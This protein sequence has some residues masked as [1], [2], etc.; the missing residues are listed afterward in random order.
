MTLGDDKPCIYI[1][2]ISLWFFTHDSTKQDMWSTKIYS[3]F[4]AVSCRCIPIS[5]CCAERLFSR[6]RQA[7][8]AAGICRCWCTTLRRAHHWWG[9]WLVQWWHV[10]TGRIE[11]LESLDGE[12]RPKPTRQNSAAWK[13]VNWPARWTNRHRLTENWFSSKKKKETFAET[14]YWINRRSTQSQCQWYFYDKS[15]LHGSLFDLGL[16]QQ[17]FGGSRGPT[18]KTSIR[19]SW[20]GK[21]EVTVNA[22]DKVLQESISPFQE[23]IGTTS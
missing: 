16:A 2:G 17:G 23:E 12:F 18:R 8:W 15:T 3:M 4:W 20:V 22:Y 19:L 7:P 13:P 5:R 21:S 14:T 10:W 1:T 9:S 6:K 11:T